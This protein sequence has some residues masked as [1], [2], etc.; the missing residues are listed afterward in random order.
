MDV[1]ITTT[2]Q[3]LD[4]LVD[5]RFGR[6]RYFLFLDKD[7][8]LEESVENPGV[9][10]IRGAAVVGSQEVAQRGVKFL[11]TGNVGPNA[12]DLLTRSGVHIFTVSTPVSAREAFLMWQDGKL[13]EL[14]MPSAGG[15][16]GGRGYGRGGGYGGGFGRGG[17]RGFGRQW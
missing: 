15:G 7:G 2:G 16:F 1:C 13:K 6:C 12:F 10:A 8:N 3:D 5:P 14:Q 4:S 17:R 9:G 11:I